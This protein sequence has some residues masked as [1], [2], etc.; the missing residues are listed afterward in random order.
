MPATTIA[1]SLLR[2]LARSIAL[3]AAVLLTSAGSSAPV[4][5]Q[6]TP[7]VTV[8]LTAQRMSKM[9]PDG[10]SVPMWG[11]CSTGSCS[12]NW[13]P[14]PTITVPTGSGLTI[15]LSNKLPTPTSLVILGQ[16]GG[17]LGN[18]AKFASPAHQAQTT[19]TWPNITPSTFTPPTQGQRARSFGTEAPVGGV[20]VAYTWSALKPGTYLY[21]TGTHPSIQQPMGLYGLLVVTAAPVTPRSGVPLAVTGITTPGLAYPPNPVTGFAGVITKLN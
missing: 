15:N 11:Y 17:N 13:T 18:P 19:T 21:A 7:T 10:K 4:Q 2:N 5:A 12:A 1:Q 14:G 6:A 8:N 3:S 9:L 20:A 16:I